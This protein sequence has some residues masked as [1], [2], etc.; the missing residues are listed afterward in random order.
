MNL[1]E[2][3]IARSDQLNADDLLSGPRT[4]TIKEVRRGD[5]DQ[6]VSIVLAEFPA[7]RPFKPSKTVLRVLVYAFGEETDDWPPNVRMTL[8]RD[9]D[10][11]WAGQA[12]GGI[13]VSH[14]SHIGKQLKIALAESKGKKTLHTVDPLP[15]N[16]P[17]SVTVSPETL[18]ELTT[19]FERKGIAEDKRLEGVN[20]YTKGAATALEVITEEQ[21]RHML[22]VLADKPDAATETPD[23]PT[24]EPPADLWAQE[25]Q[26]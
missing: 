23:V 10:V 16:A 17:S 13:R 19:L 26:S 21:A 8:Y 6:P 22:T 14:L 12:I 20:Y 15:D 18:A 2:A 11:K 25:G 24:E 9:A 5:N 4:F 3:I 7:N 1:S